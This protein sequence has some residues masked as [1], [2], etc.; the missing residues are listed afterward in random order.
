[1]SHD[2]TARLHQL[3]GDYLA[4]TNNYQEALDQYTQALR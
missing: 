1:M 3:L 4:L 2:R